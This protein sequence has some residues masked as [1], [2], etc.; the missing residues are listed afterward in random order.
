MNICWRFFTVIAL[1]GFVMGAQPQQTFFI[2][3]DAQIHEPPAD[4]A[5]VPLCTTADTLTI[6]AYA[7]AVW[8]KYDLSDREDCLSW[9]AGTPEQFDEFLARNGYRRFRVAEP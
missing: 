3:A 2:Y 9:E 1:A 8:G 6:A 4:A 7:G 5:T